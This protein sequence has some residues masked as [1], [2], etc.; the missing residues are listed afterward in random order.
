MKILITGNMGYV[1]S[2]LVRHLRSVFPKS[3]LIGFDQAYFGH[4]LTGPS[5]LPESLLDEQLFG[6]VR[7][8]LPSVFEGVEGVV[9][10]A[11]VSNDPMGNRYE[12]VTGE[13]NYKASL[14]IAQKALKA[15]VR[16]FVF[17]SSC[18]VYG[19]AE[20]GPR[21]E[22]DPL[23]PLT[24]Y[25]RSK[26]ATEEFL[27][28]LDQ[29]NMTVTSLR[30]ATAC[31]MSDRLRLDLVLNDFVACALTSGK[32]S[33]L[34]DGTPW[35]PLIDVKDMA[36]AIEWALVRKPSEGGQYLAVNVGSATWNYQVRDLA[37]AVA[38]MITGTEV[39]VNPN[40]A[41]DK[42][43]YQ[44]DFSLY[45][46]LAPNHQPQI[47]L[48]QTISEIKAGLERM[49][50]KDQIFRESQLI[51]LKVLER[52]ITEKRLSEELEWIR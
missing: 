3:V 49:D 50:F 14:D 1:G 5:S 12:K 48:D 8:L 2:V 43:S 31:G 23:N 11:A 7:H 30:F 13:I 38:S 32:I 29:K 41:P 42:R 18:S 46:S 33:I 20:G 24:S 22:S 6:D 45:R 27:S 10:L 9:H 36:R 16:N 15:G 40:A 52:H 35:R 39:S 34:S 25:A 47:T 19:A 17:A 51:R 4:C 28:Q 21:K 44:V 26:I 37:E